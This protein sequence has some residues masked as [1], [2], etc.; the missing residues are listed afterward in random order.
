MSRRKHSGR[1]R[2]RRPSHRKFSSIDQRH[3]NMQ[4]EA[5]DPRVLLTANPAGEMEDTLAQVV[6][7]VPQPITRG[8]N[9]QLSQA[10]N[11]IVVHFNENDLLD[12]PTSAENPALYQLIFTQDTITNTDDR[13][14]NP[15]LVQYDPAANQAT[16]TF[17]GDLD[18]LAGETGTYRLR[19]GTS[20]R[21]PATPEVVPVTDAGS[22]FVT[23]IDVGTIGFDETLNAIR[24]EAKIISGAIDPEVF[25]LDF[26]GG[27]DDPGHRDLP[28]Q[29]HFALQTGDDGFSIEPSDTEAGIATVPYNFQNV[30][31]FDPRG[32]PL[33]N[34]ITE[35]Q[36]QR[37]REVFDIYGSLLGV[38][39]YETRDSGLTI[40]TGDLRALV[41]FALPTGEGQILAASGDTDPDPDVFAPTAIMDNAEPWN[42]AFGGEL[43]SGCDARNRPPAW[44]GNNT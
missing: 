4:I 2:Q 27:S 16:L 39:F 31:G 8:A 43:V 10:R 1:G 12:G 32:T 28:G 21:R 3:R 38:Q 20:E 7:V 30:Y 41:D 11:Q 35:N 23:S 22:S 6:A 42:D 29:P 18:G 44:S 17:A 40:A 5:L 26:P 13:R 36:R 25:P 15:T 19:I 37:A 9:G 14:F 34:L 24:T 33:L